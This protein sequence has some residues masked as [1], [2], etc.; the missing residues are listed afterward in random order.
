MA[1]KKIM[2]RA[3]AA[4]ALAA[5]PMASAE[6]GMWT[7]DA[8]PSARM[9]AEIGWAPDA[10][11]LT[12]VRA[13]AARLQGGCSSSIVGGEGLVLTNDHCVVGCVRDLSTANRNLIDNGFVAAARNEELRCPGMAI[14]VLTDI[15]DV[16][17]RIGQA[18]AGAAADAFTAARDAEIAR[19][20]S[21]CSSGAARCEVVTLYQGGRYSLYSYRRFDDVRLA[22]V[23]EN[24][25]A[26]YGGNLTDFEF[27][28][29][30]IDFALVRLYE[31]GAPATTPSR[32]RMRFTP[33][34]AGEPVMVAGNPGSTSR[35]RTVAEL[36][37]T[38][39]YALPATLMNMGEMRGRVQ[40]Y[41]NLG[42]D[43]ERAATTVLRGLENGFKS[44]YGR[45]LALVNE[46]AFA[47]L[48]AREA[49]FRQRV[50]RNRTLRRDV[51]EAWGEIER[52]KAAQRG[53]HMQYTYLEGGP[54]G[55]TLFGWA[56]D[57]VRAAEE[58]GKPDGARLPRYS[59]ARLPAVEQGIRAVRPVDAGL[60]QVVLT[61]WLT[62]LQA[63]LGVND[64]GTVA[65]IGRANPDAL[66]RSLS[67]SRLGDPAYRAQ[68][69]EG[70]T[71]A[72]AASD[73]PMIQFVRRWDGQA[74]ALHTRLLE[75]V[76]GPIARA[77]ERLA[78]ARFQ[79]YGENQYPD[80]TFSLRL[81]YG[82]VA[83]LTEPD[84]RVV[85]P[86]GRAGEL[87]DNNTNAFPFN[88]AQSWR[89]AESRV[90][91]NAILSVATTNDIIGGNSGSPLLDR[92]GRV[93]GVAWDGNI[94][95]LGGD[96]FY[97]GTL[98]RTVVVAATGIELV[99]RDVYRADAL[100]AELRN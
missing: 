80:A 83:G 53:F 39:D 45:R 50:S 3:V 90:D 79:I 24:T 85:S 70:G 12:R 61:L 54:G 57:L 68:L 41:S 2:L 28:A 44:L 82:R 10:D 60:E 34:E 30:C 84:G 43:Q 4:L 25:M 56:R 27:P 59:Q 19:I 22:F 76:D 98:N 15:S 66:A 38:R 99:L 40:A 6:E 36:E 63:N 37:F 74:R 52:A 51:G 93:V 11:W 78:R 1:A 88:L 31:N 32:L 77:H 48:V 100:L 86:F 55:S 20:E 64:A 92:E 42:A 47:Q 97:D 21:E 95:S 67:Q 9:R 7:F 5:A 13:G 18:T 17:T 89:A 46:T 94:H 49:D 8:V 73:D 87:Y 96:Y 91:R 65:V 69:W 81:S 62:R 16:T 29:H 71:A 14:Q 23:P 33:L 26:Q 35:L 72:I 75:E 58:R